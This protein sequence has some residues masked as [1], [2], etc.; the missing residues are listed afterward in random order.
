MHISPSVREQFNFFE[1]MRA[2]I[3]FRVPIR[4]PPYT[5]P[6]TPPVSLGAP[7]VVTAKR[8]RIQSEVA[9]IVVKILT[10]WT[11]GR[12]SP[13]RRPHHRRVHQALSRGF[14]GC[15]QFGMY[16]TC[17]LHQRVFAGYTVILDPTHLFV[18][19]KNIPRA[20]SAS[21]GDVARA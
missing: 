11:M 1:I 18:Q 4:G 14:F 7:G 2:V 12:Q 17:A 15:S 3:V 20:L 6:S 16:P 8:S 5:T 21:S 19:E 13:Q 9:M 10:E